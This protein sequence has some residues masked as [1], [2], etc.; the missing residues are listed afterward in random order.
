MDSELVERLRQY[1]SGGGCVVMVPGEPTL[2]EGM[3]PLN[4]PLPEHVTTGV[5]ELVST[6]IEQAER[7]GIEA[8]VAAAGAEATVWR[9]EAGQ[10]RVLFVANP[11]GQSSKAVISGLG[12]QAAYDAFEGQPVELNDLRL[13]PF[14]VRMLRLEG[15]RPRGGGNGA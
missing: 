15:D 6:L 3:R 7:L 1:V 2:D 9:D 8:D 10:P 4:R 14:E 11:Q 5:E 12:V 13:K